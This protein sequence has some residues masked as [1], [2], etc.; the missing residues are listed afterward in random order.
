M[1]PG[2]RPE[3]PAGASSRMKHSD[4]H[5]H[6][7]GV[8]LGCRVGG[9]TST[10]E[11]LGANAVATSQPSARP[12]FSSFLSS[13]LTCTPAALYKHLARREEVGVSRD[14]NLQAAALL[15]SRPR[16]LKGGGISGYILGAHL[17]SMMGPG[18]TVSVAAVAVAAAA[19]A[20]ARKG[21]VT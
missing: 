10:A 16:T 20:A 15:A 3:R 12:L 5:G 21:G 2:W 18:V 1:P 14:S 4:A 9:A 19:A 8:V 13:C 17:S 6:E 11:P 7:Q